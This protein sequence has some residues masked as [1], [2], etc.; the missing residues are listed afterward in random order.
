MVR[1][2]PIDDATLRVDLPPCELVTFLA[3][4]KAAQVACSAEEIV[5]A[6]DTLCLVKDRVLGKPK[7]IHSAREMISSL[8]GIS[9]E[10]VT[11]IAIKSARSVNCWFDSATVTLGRLSDAQRE[12]YLASQLWRGKAGGYNYA[13]Q[14]EA[15]WPLTCDGDPTTVMG[16]PMRL[17]SRELKQRLEE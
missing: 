14:V 17:L 13:E 16:L 9:H 10:V 7:D 12:S 2:A 8:E 4:Y 5:L 1:P 6:A 11:G 3:H 15:G